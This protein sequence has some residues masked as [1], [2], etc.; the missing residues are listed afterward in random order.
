M[1]FHIAPACNGDQLDMGFTRPSNSIHCAEQIAP[2]EDTLT[3]EQEAA[4]DEELENAVPAPL[5]KLLGIGPITD[6]ASY[7]Q[8]R[9]KRPQE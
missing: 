2:R 5:Q 8:V 1:P 3:A 4:A 6:A 9:K 7:Y